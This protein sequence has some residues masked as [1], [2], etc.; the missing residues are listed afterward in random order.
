MEEERVELV[1]SHESS[2]GLEPADG[3]FDDPAF[4]I[5]PQWSSVLGRRSNTAAA[6]RADQLDPTVSQSLTQGITVGSPVIDQPVGH[7]RCDG[8]I[9][10]RLDQC[11]FSGAGRVYVD[12]QWQAV[13]IDQEHKLAAFAALGGANAISPFF[14]DA[15]VP[16]A[17]P[18]SQFSWPR[19][20]S[21]WSKRS[22]ASSQ[23][24]LKDHSANRRQQVTYEGYERGRSFQ[25]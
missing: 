21:C 15:N 17:K 5:T 14:A 3:A 22:Q 23:T 13:P 18:S 1:A 10:Q 4:S 16:S 11:D 9:K 2:E 19:S 7:V 8:L 24:P 20:S 25:R 12:S 6:M